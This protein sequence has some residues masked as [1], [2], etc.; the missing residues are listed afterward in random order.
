MKDYVY[1]NETR[2]MR[3]TNEKKHNCD[4]NVLISIHPHLHKDEKGSSDVK[5]T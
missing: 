5:Y 2:H 1:L 3:S 4:H